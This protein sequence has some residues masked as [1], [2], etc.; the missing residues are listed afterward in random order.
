MNRFEEVGAGIE[1]AHQAG[2]GSL[3]NLA[4]IG[5]QL[6]KGLL[7]VPIDGPCNYFANQGVLVQRAI[8]KRHYSIFL[9][10]TDNFRKYY[11][12]GAA[13]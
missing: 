9:D 12:E 2:D 13:D 11:A 7:G 3:G 5:L 1:R 10:K 4:Q 8:L 6:R